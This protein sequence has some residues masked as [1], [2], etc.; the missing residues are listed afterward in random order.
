M[1]GTQKLAMMAW[2]NIKM[3][4]KLAPSGVLLRAEISRVHTSHYKSGRRTVNR[5]AHLIIL[6]KYAGID[7]IGAYNLTREYDE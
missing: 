2:N 4:H 6:A 3:E 7:Y 5:T 1:K